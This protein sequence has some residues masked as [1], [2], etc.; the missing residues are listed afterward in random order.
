MKKI[1]AR[2]AGMLIF[3]NIISLKFI[4]YPAIFSKYAK[5][6]AYIAVAI[7]ILIDLTIL[8]ILIKIS[9]KD[10]NKTFFSC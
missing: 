2:Q 8:A 9:K 10:V 6:D 1:N 5:Q 4:T 7:N 3:F